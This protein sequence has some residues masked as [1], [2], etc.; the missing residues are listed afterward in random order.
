MDVGDIRQADAN[1]HAGVKYLRS[2]LERNFADAT[3]EG[4]DQALFA[5]ASYNAGPARVA[6]LRAEAKQKGLDPDRWFDHVEPIAARR[7]GRETVRYVRYIYKYYVAYKL[8][9]EIRAVRE[10]VKSEEFGAP[11]P[12]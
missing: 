6:R 12:P 4:E 7:I 3:L 9:A 1:V 8:A 10:A 2:M 5:F 11:T